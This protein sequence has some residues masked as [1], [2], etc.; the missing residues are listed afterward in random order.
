MIPRLS[1]RCFLNRF[2]IL[3]GNDD[4][5]NVQEASDRESRDGRRPSAGHRPQKLHGDWRLMIAAPLRIDAWHVTASLLCYVVGVL[6]GVAF[7]D[8]IFSPLA[9]EDADEPTHSVLLPARSFYDLSQRRAPAALSSA[10]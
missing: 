6:P 7:D 8:S 2:H 3:I 9:A 1:R 10:R 4:P 5:L